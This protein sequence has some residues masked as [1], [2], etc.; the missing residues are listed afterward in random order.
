MSCDEQGRSINENN[1]LRENQYSEFSLC[2]GI[3]KIQEQDLHTGL[4]VHIIL[5]VN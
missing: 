4:L 1:C 3:Q 2:S 5:H